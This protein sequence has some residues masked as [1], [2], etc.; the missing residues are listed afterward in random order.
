MGS[1]DVPPLPSP[2]YPNVSIAGRL[3]KSATPLMVISIILCS[4]RA[5]SRIRPVPN[6]GV[7]DLT[8]FVAVVRND[9][10]FSNSAVKRLIQMQ[11]CATAHW[12]IILAAISYGFGRHN[13][14]VSPEFKE[15]AAKTL[16]FSQ[17]S[18]T[19]AVVLA[20]ISIAFLL[21][22]IKNTFRWKVFLYVMVFIQIASA[23][24]AN[25]IQ[26]SHCRP[27]AANWDFSIP[28][29]RCWPAHVSQTGMIAFV[30]IGIA[31]DIVFTC[32]PLSFIYSIK[33][34][35][36]EK[37]VL[38]FIS[39]LGVLT[40]LA[41]IIKTT[42]QLRHY[43]EFT[44][45]LYNGIDLVLWAT[46]EEQVGIIAACIPCLKAP[47]EKLLRRVGL[48]PP[49]RARQESSNWKIRRNGHA[50]KSE[51]DDLTTWGPGRAMKSTAA[52]SI[53]HD[54]IGSEENMLSIEVGHSST[55]GCNCS[56]ISYNLSGQHAHET[57][58]I[59]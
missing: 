31:T 56:S 30:A 55:S 42:T 4:I 19:W 59:Q 8:I 7:D 11:L 26:F 45:V 34:P 14:Y 18:W 41:A 17:F 52:I 32:I 37:I 50:S 10:S 6:L 28:R 2:P 40:S 44:D 53:S 29:T 33:R 9:V 35:L 48:L 27:V 3:I 1:M 16:F 39:G 24:V 46:V 5:Y 38:A 47:G 43:G 15:K 22:R 13:I 25:T 58:E 36:L 20:K 12:A 23:I 57:H 51:I 54:N 49:D 21:Y